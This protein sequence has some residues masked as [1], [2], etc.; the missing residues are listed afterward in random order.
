MPPLLSPGSSRSGAERKT[1]PAPLR[2]KRVPA[3]G[4]EI[5]WRTVVNY[6]LFFITAVLVVDALIGDKGFMDTLRVRREWHDL[7]RSV[8]KLRDE[9]ARLVEQAR[10]LRDDPATLEGIAREEHG[11]IRPGEVLFILKDVKPASR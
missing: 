10:R 7:A 6:L 8:E 11:M 5:R 9:N 3:P 2:R 1:G 4:P